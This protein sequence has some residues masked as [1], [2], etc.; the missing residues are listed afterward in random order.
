[1]IFIAGFALEGE[2]NAMKLESSAFTNEGMVPSKYTCDGNDVSPPLSWSGAPSGTKSFA[3]IAD[4]P[5]APMGTWVHWVV[6]NIPPSTDK[7]AENVPADRRLDDG[8][9]QGINDFKRAGYGGPCP[10]GGKHRYYFKLYALDT[11]L[12]LGESTGKVALEK[13]MKDH[14]LA[15]AQLMGRYER[16]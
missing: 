10:P 2:A 15:E 16:K 8:M 11:Q 12:S 3:L 9:R 7:L 14:V 5:D 1:M 4:D 6:W 13:A